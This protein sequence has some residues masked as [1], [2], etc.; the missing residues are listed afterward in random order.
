MMGRLLSSILMLLFIAVQW[1]SVHSYGSFSEN[2]FQNQ[3]VTMMLQSEVN[4]TARE[5]L[6]VMHA[7]SFY[8]VMCYDQLGCFGKEPFGVLPE[9]PD[10]I[11]P[12]F[13]LYTKESISRPAIVYEFNSTFGSTDTV[14]RRALRNTSRPLV[15]I[16]HGFG[17]SSD[18]EWMQKLCEIKINYPHETNVILV[19]WKQGARYS[20]LYA[21]AA[22]NT[23]L[24]GRM[25]AYF[26]LRLVDEFGILIRNVQF[27]GFSLGGQMSGFFAEQ[28]FRA[29]RQ[30]IGKITALDTAAPLFEAYGVYP[31]KEYSEYMEAVHTSAGSTVWRGKV[32]VE[33]NYGHVDFYPNGGIDQPGCSFP[34]VACAH[35]RAVE[36]YIEAL[37]N[38]DH[39]VYSGFLCETVENANRGD[40]ASEKDNT[41]YLT[42]S[43]A[44]INGAIY[45]L[46][47]DSVAP[48]CL[49]D[50]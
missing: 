4:Q 46:K 49:H 13:E 15:F 22:A 38:Q 12:E 9:A 25:A 3:L 48:Y 50:I 30:P 47:T 5:N 8:E 41:H 17:G 6:L 40:C 7:G 14:T 34:N 39:C 35:Y 26:C 42:M 10:Y 28:I 21:G 33:V 19:N 37:Q 1:T 31:R 18:N 43:R 20:T 45:F 32:G 44:Q 29:K 24:V 2:N 27:I 11:R 23:A 36:Y 16:A